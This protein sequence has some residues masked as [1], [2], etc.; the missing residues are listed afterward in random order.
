LFFFSLLM[1]GQSQP[2]GIANTGSM[3]GKFRHTPGKYGG[4]Q[5]KIAEVH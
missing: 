4:I 5:C 2:S 1:S 3:L